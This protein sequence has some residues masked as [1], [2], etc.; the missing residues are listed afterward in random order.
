MI[1]VSKRIWFRV[2]KVFDLENKND[3]SEQKDLI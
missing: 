2:Q 3:L 1:W